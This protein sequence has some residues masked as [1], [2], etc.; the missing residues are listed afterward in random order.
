[1]K[2][3]PAF[4]FVIIALSTMGAAPP[5][6][7]GTYE[8]P[9]ELRDTI[10][11][12]A[13]RF[14]RS[15][16]QS[17]WPAAAVRLPDAAA[18]ALGASL[19][20]T[21]GVDIRNSGGDGSVT[22]LSNWGVFNRHM[23]LLYNG[24]VVKDYS[25]GGFN[26]SDFSSEEVERIEIIK[27]PQSAFYGSDA[28]GGVVNLISRSS[29]ADR[30][31]VTTKFGNLGYRTYH[32]DLSRAIGPLGIGGFAEYCTSRNRRDNAGTRRA[33]Y[34]LRS[35]YLSS[36]NRHRAMVSAR[37]FEDS[38]GVPGPVPDP[39]FIPVYGNKES[40]S[41]TDR[42][43]D[44]NYS[45]D[46]QYRLSGQNFG[47]LQIDLFWERK[48]LRFNR[49]YNYVS[50]LNSDSVDV[51]SASIYN[52][53]SSGV[54]VRFLHEAQA[55]QAGGGIDWLSGSLGATAEDTNLATGTMGP[56]ALYSYEFYTFN[57]WSGRQNQ[58]DAW[59]NL[60]L[61]A[62]KTVRLDVSGRLQF[63][64]NRTTQ[65][66]Y[67]VGF[68]VSLSPK[69]VFKGGYGYAFR[70]P[71]VA[72]QFADDFFTA[73]NSQLS[74]EVAHTFQ[75]TVACNPIASIV[76]A[77]VTLFRQ[78]INRL[79]QYQYDTTTFRS[80]PQNVQRF[81]TIG[82]D[83]SLSLRMGSAVTW[84]FGGVAQQARQSIGDDREMTDAFYVPNIKWR[85]DIDWSHGRFNT[86]IHAVFTADRTIRLFDG[87]EKRI[88]KV[89]E[90]GFHLTARIHRHA[91]MYLTGQD[92]THRCR[93]DQFGYTMG[94]G[95]YPTLGPR[96]IVGARLDTF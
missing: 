42:Q 21:A 60:F 46:A 62:L 24:R 81:R 80:I 56:V 65:P 74:P 57:F 18:T 36:D 50:L 41:L 30:I 8:S 72:E 76:T 5:R 9:H 27:G 61:S 85:T 14:G 63:V 54:N 40:S 38:I 95:D 69:I 70:L 34:G 88:A 59:G 87:S 2:C 29:L 84:R 71:T 25:L 3:S 10:I 89:Y 47:E 53:R 43:Q 92:V 90:L 58:F 67:N 45:F 33:V 52:K 1:M 51:Y 23:L 39:T 6:D 82:I 77:D 83:A 17:I 7:T 32:V 86:N 11:V 22:T 49:L 37:Y 16:E 94:D 26:L 15:A 12:T 35:D 75:A 79:I 48:N 20:G 31:G 44:E 78:S 96:I 64:R 91:S 13:N 19:D 73:G 28:V 55:F 66:S 93:P 68:I 4:A